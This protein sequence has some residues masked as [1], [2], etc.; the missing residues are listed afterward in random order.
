MVQMAEHAHD[1]R[2]PAAGADE[3]QLLRRRVRQHKV[4]LDIA[5]RDDRPGLCAVHEIWGDHTGV[6]T[7]GS[8][9]DEPVLPVRVRGQRVRPP[10]AH[11]V[12]VYSDP[13]VLPRLMAGPPVAGFDQHRG[14]VSRLPP[15][16]FDAAPQLAR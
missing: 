5:E 14:G 8:D 2:Y 3:Q 16:L 11:P 6:D 12:Y 1:R 9:A 10:M 13:D 15:N 7:L 4:A